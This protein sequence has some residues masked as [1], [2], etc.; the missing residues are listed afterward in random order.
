MRKV[1][2]KSEYANA[3]QCLR[4]AYRDYQNSVWNT[5]IYKPSRLN[6]HPNETER[7]VRII[8]PRGQKI[9]DPRLTFQEL[10]IKTIKAMEKGV[11]VIYN[12]VFICPDKEYMF[13]GDVMVKGT[14]RY[15]L[16]EVKSGIKCRNSDVYDIGF[17]KMVLDL[18]YQSRKHISTDES[19]L[20]KKPMSA[21]YRF[22]ER[23]RIQNLFDIDMSL[24]FI[25]KDYSLNKK[26]DAKSMIKFKNINSRVRDNQPL[27]KNIVSRYIY[28][29][30]N[31]QIP[32]RARVIG[33][34]RPKLCEYYDECWDESKSITHHIYNAAIVPVRNEKGP[35]FF[36]TTVS[37]TIKPNKRFD[38]RKDDK[39]ELLLSEISTMSIAAMSI[40]SMNLSIP[41]LKGMKP[42][43]PL[44]RILSIMD[45]SAL[46]ELN[47]EPYFYFES[48]KYDPRRRFIFELLSATE[49]Y[50]SI[51]IFGGKY[52]LVSLLES[53][54]KMNYLPQKVE[55]LI[56]KTV[57]I[58]AVFLDYILKNHNYI[59]RMGI[60]SLVRLLFPNIE[61][62]GS[63]KDDYA[64][65]ILLVSY[66][67]SKEHRKLKIEE[68]L[69]EYHNTRV[70]C[71]H[72]I[73]AHL[74]SINKKGGSM[75]T[76]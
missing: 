75:D 37:E 48:T 65:N 60:F 14:Y 74:N 64:A 62:T 44:P 11:K 35:L 7:L 63:L 21:A 57:D 68:Q 15:R 16:I 69:S 50:E 76:S 25:N 40:Q 36:P 13:I 22:K 49:K 51:V 19:V 24:A 1:I 27:V 59:K 38:L 31:N 34:I 41:I 23:V 47:T 32:V 73:L 56:S 30:R 66:D 52:L 3:A 8:H 33:C 43:E 58:E 55:A 6:D 29:I 17:Q 42:L 54:K 5:S 10:F 20:T 46:N 26:L 28:S 67:S 45:C 12:P 61:C 70:R 2:T 53:A 4:R 9:L 39:L 71:L 72:L 18:L